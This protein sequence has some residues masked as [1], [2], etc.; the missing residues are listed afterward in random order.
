[1]AGRG[2]VLVAWRCCGLGP[3]TDFSGGREAAEREVQLLW[4]MR[5]SEAR[6][7]VEGMGTVALTIPSPEQLGSRNLQDPDCSHLGEHGLDLG[8]CLQE[9]ICGVPTSIKVT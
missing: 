1:M 8:Q 5:R 3:K 6:S 2:K 9:R 4:K 7:Q